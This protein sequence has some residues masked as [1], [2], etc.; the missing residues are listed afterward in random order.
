MKK[1]TD[2]NKLA[3]VRLGVKLANLDIKLQ[4]LNAL[5]LEDA[6]RYWKSKSLLCAQKHRLM[7]GQDETPIVRKAYFMRIKNFDRN[8]TRKLMLELKNN[9]SE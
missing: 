4:Q 3:Q 1:S 5:E 9:T 7:Y 6:T 2:A 8:S